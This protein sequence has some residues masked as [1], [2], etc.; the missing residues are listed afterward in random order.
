ML[1]LSPTERRTL[2]ARAHDLDPVVAIA[3][4]G[5]SDAVLKEIDGCLRAHELVKVRVY[6]DSRDEREAYMAAICEQLQ[7]AAVQH[8][9]K[10]L[11]VWRPLS[12][13]DRAA[14][15]AT[16]PRRNAPRRTKRSYQS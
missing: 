15:K 9:G 10:L 4:N 3:Q 11:I 12:D 16:K 1:Q 8:I 13:A 6:S 7:A 14:A 5:L 2:R